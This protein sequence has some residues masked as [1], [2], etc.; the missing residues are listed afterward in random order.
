MQATPSTWRLML[1]AGWVGKSDLKLL[2]GGEALSRD[3]ATALIPRVGQLWNMYGPTETTIWSTIARVEDP[4]GTIP[5]GRPIANSRVYVLEPSGMLAPIGA[6]G[7]LVIAGE[8][9]ARG[10]WNQAALTAEKFTNITLPDGCIE[11]AYRT[12]DIVR[13]RVDGLLE[14]QGPI[15]SGEIG[16]YR[17]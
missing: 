12:G 3:L 5:I 11:R 10:Y 6:F 15:T 2:C 14:F 17:I 9:V 1:E 8:G 13:F 7:E 4:T 16:G